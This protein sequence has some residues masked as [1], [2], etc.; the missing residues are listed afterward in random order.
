M[1]EDFVGSTR[2]TYDRVAADYQR[3]N[4]VAADQLSAFRS[5]FSETVSG[6]VVDLGCGPGRDVRWLREQGLDAFGMDLSDGMLALA[7]EASV[8]VV[9]GDLRNPPLK[10][11]A[12]DG[13]WSSAALL[14]VPRVDVAGALAA[15]HWLLRA[16]GRL[17]LSTS[18]G[19]DEG[20]ELVPYA[21]EGPTT[22]LHRWFVHH[23]AEGLCDLLA[24]A[25]FTVLST[26]I[27]SSNRDWLMVH[28][29][30]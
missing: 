10:A 16:G 13:I 1:H 4:A 3:K 12:L 14:H 29:I 2:A 11:G 27:R 7:R 15:W 23:T 5:A 22:D 21:Q 30:A 19:G 8:P 28:A 25:G 17:S 24:A 26:D 18:L 6:T 9:Q 20:W